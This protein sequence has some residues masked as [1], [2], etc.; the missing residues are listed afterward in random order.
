M[1]PGLHHDIAAADYHADPC[2]EPSLS[3][4]IAKIILRDTPRHAWH[5][6]PRLN[7]A[8]E[9]KG[10]SKFD[11]GSV[12]HELILGKGGG[13]DVLPEEFGDYKKGKA[14]ELRD[15]S[16]LAGRT[17]IL[18]HQFID[19][20]EMA[21]HV[22]ARLAEIGIHPFALPTET[23]IV[24]HDWRDVLCRAMLDAADPEAAIVYDY[25]STER[26]LSDEAIARTIDALGYDLSAGFYLRGLNRVLPDLAGRWRFRW[27]FFETEEPFEVRV[28]EATRPTLEIG[29]R[30]AAFALAR[31]E[32]CLR[33]GEWPGWPNKIVAGGLNDF[34]VDKWINREADDP[35]AHI[36]PISTRVLPSRP[37]ELLEAV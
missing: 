34:A 6:H 3:S 12:A 35:D 11:L 8:F 20:Q 31:W 1:K 23:V 17:P 7:P 24:W 13:F 30:K 27:V 33:S 9:P 29:D 18:A 19:A 4:S 32:R 14:Q 15:A 5:A 26:G 2:D 37:S 22:G 28:V 25:K 16:R 21:G 10:E 36:A